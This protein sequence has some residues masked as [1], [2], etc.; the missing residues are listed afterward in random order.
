MKLASKYV[1]RRNSPTSTSSTIR[2]SWVTECGTCGKKG[3]SIDTYWVQ[4]FEDAIN[5]KKERYCSEYCLHTR[6]K[7]RGEW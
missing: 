7:K 4:D 2:D 6:I 3:D 1:M 5:H